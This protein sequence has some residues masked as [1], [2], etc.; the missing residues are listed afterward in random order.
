CPGPLAPGD[1]IPASASSALA[2]RTGV[3]LARQDYT[4]TIG[5][6]P[7]EAATAF[8][9]IRLGP[10]VSEV[11]GAFHALGFTEKPDADTATEY[12]ATGQYRWNA[13]RFRRR[14]RRLLQHLQTHQPQP[15]QAR[16]T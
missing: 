6:R 1:V 13:G 3:A 15:C 11:P 5:I 4:A 9:Y 7:T 2:P 10:A 8:G 14:A 12:L 16:A